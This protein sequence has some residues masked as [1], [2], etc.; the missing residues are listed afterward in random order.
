M[1][2][3]IIR[4]LEKYRRPYWRVV[5][6][7]GQHRVPVTATSYGGC[8]LTNLMRTRAEAESL[9]M[10]CDMEGRAALP[11]EIERIPYNHPIVAYYIR[12][13]DA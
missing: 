10:Y 13:K 2:K 3:F 4:L 9:Q 7:E 11:T 8:P 1:R 6:I 12:S 5:W